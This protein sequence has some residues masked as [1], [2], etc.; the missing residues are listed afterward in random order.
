[1][2]KN[3]IQLGDLALNWRQIGLGSRNAVITRDPRSS[4]GLEKTHT[5]ATGNLF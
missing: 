1:M 2:C 5:T 4:S 3:G